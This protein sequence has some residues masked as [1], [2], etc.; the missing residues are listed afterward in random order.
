LSSEIV[1]NAVGRLLIVSRTTMP[2]YR[3]LE[4]SAFE[5]EHVEAMAI[6][7]EDLCRELELAQPENPLREV[8]ARQVIEFA[9]RG[10]RDPAKLRVLVMEAIK[11]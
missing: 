5:P 1:G 3:L 2:L 7:F 11:A 8:V 6:A 4:N 10:E 9:R